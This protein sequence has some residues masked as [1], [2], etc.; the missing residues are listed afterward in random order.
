VLVHSGYSGVSTSDGL[1][2]K[3]F[4][5]EERIEPLI[6]HFYSMGRYMK[7]VEP[8]GLR[9]TCDNSVFCRDLV[10]HNSRSSSP[11]MALLC[12]PLIFAMLQYAL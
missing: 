2:Q 4:A 12:F 7:G 5:R 8:L 3:L 1:N 10:R 6:L 9:I 11:A